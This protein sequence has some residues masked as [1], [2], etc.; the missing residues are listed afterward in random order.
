MNGMVA[1]AAVLKMEIAVLVHL[2]KLLGCESYLRYR[3][4]AIGEAIVESIAVTDS[5]NV[6]YLVP[7]EVGVE[8]IGGER[9]LAIVKLALAAR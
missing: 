5:D 1:L 2:I 7:E 6:S 4:S 8:S 3:N 9:L